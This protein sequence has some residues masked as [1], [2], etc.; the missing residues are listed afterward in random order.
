MTNLRVRI[1]RHSLSWAMR[2]D[3]WKTSDW[4][5]A[6]DKGVNEDKVILLM[7]AWFAKMVKRDVLSQ[8]IRTGYVLI[9]EL[10]A[11]G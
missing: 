10:M 2:L 9:V 3:T 8:C 4:H 6:A 11:S 1:I 7:T 5:V